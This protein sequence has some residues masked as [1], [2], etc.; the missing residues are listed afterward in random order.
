MTTKPLP[1]F[2]KALDDLPGA[3]SDRREWSLR[4]DAEFAAAQRYLRKTGKLATAVDCPSP[5]GDGCPRAVI[6][7]PTGGFRAVCRASVGQCDALELTGWDIGIVE[8]DRR[9]L[10]EDLASI[11]CTHP[12]GPPIDRGRVIHL[13]QHA[14]AAGVAAPV[15]FLI[16]GPD[17]PLSDD[18]MRDG[19][20]GRERAVL[21]VPTSG[22]LLPSL[23][24]RLSGQG[25]QVV[26][27]AEVTAANAEG[28]LIPVQPVEALLNT[29]RGALHARLDGVRP[30]PRIT[31]PADATWAEMTF[32]LISDEVLNVSFRGQTSRLEPDQLG[33]KNHRSGKPT[34]AWELL[35]VLARK[36][37]IIGP[38]GRDGVEEQKKRKQSLTKRL[39]QSFGITATL[40]RW[41]PKGREYQTVFVIR[42]ERPKAVRMR[43]E[44]R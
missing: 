22:S 32:V 1:Q 12:S 14:V 4:L 23:R 19:G 43:A 20:F 29:V 41:N 33:V 30:G 38:L 9:R 15:L 16:P 27:L 35:Q 24:A 44:R 34:D 2:W 17:M 28:L 6:R 37:G 18:E 8:L 11:F 7:L 25:H 3:A 42:D 36:G 5:G 40:V 21:L 26:S 10:H 39:M 31:L 13:G